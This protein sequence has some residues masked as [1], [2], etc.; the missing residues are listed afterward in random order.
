MRQLR[1][2]L[3]WHNIKDA[4]EH[5]FDASGDVTGEGETDDAPFCKGRNPEAETP[6]Q[7]TQSFLDRATT[8]TTTHKRSWVDVA[9]FV[10]SLQSQGVPKRICEDVVSQFKQFGTHVECELKGG[11]DSGPC[12]QSVAGLSNIDTA[13]KMN[14][15]AKKERGYISPEPQFPNNARKPVSQFVPMT[16]QIR[17]ALECEDVF[18]GLKFEKH[19]HDKTLKDI[20][21]GSLHAHSEGSLHLILY[22]DEF[23]ISNPIGNKTKKYSIGAMYYTFANMQKRASI[24]NIYLAMLFHSS[25]MKIHSMADIMAP[26]IKE[27]TSLEEEGVHYMRNGEMK[28]VKCNLSMML[29]DNKGCH[30]MAGYFTSF[31]RTSRICRFC[32]ATTS[33]IQSCFREDK[34][35]MRTRE[36]YD[37]EVTQL[38][39]EDFDE[40]IQKLF[41]LKQRCV[42]NQ[43]PSF[44][45]IE[46]FPVDVTHDLFEKGV[47]GHALEQ[48]LYHFVQ[49]KLFSLETLNT[50]IQLFPYHAVD[51]NRPVPVKKC[52]GGLTVSQTCSETWALLRTLP[53]ILLIQMESSTSSVAEDEKYSVL[54]GLV[55]VVQQ[56]MADEFTEDSLTEL[57]GRI[58]DWLKL[59]AQE[60]PMFNLTPKFHNLVHYPSQIRLHGPLKKFAT[61]RFES[62]HQEMKRYM[63]NSRNRI[64]P[65]KSMAEAHQLTTALVLSGKCG[66]PTSSRRHGLRNLTY[67]DLTYNAGDCIAARD[68]EGQIELI[69]ISEMR[70][71]SGCAKIWGKKFRNVEYI[72]NL[73]AFQVSDERPVLT[74]V[75]ELHHHHPLGV[76][77][78]G[79]AVY[80]IPQVISQM[81][82]LSHKD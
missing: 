18:S 44:H 75:T 80:V 74:E 72:D 33:D 31:Y 54:A 6:T 70:A 30:Q 60:F 53:L 46:R 8:C 3:R 17:A 71:D 20:C 64:N 28:N 52:A 58:E 19:L 43:V 48:V 40:N 65:T 78:V 35:Q 13:F 68:A 42:F 59:Y 81:R 27:L 49:K 51:K 41:G 15:F 7:R 34:F 61:I 79:G 25:Q 69:E 14:Q 16:G 39:M 56:I 23:N 9:D 50:A 29:G 2:H 82:I 26:L 21:D 66:E 38:E 11:G 76:Y 1:D 73:K 24:H 62:K 5:T 37:S 36:Q 47:V 10:L 4:K 67:G 22:F 32:H 12:S 55:D 45:C 57:E 63:A 77:R